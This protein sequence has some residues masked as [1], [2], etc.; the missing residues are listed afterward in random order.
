M[1]THA[2]T[3]LSLGDAL[4]CFDPTVQ[5]GG[6]YTCLEGCIM[7]MSAASVLAKALRSINLDTSIQAHSPLA[8]QP[9]MQGVPT[10]WCCTPFHHSGTQM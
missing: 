6:D 5:K 8:L 9:S 2:P 4:N 7:A 1:L 10:R 3:P